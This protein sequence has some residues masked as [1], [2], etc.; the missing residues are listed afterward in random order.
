MVQHDYTD[1]A[2]DS[3]ACTSKLVSYIRQDWLCDLTT[4]AAQHTKSAK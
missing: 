1:R 3:V 2:I 4:L